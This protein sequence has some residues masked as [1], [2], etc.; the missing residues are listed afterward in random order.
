MRPTWDSKVVLVERYATLGGVCP[1][2]RLHSVQGAAVAAVMDEVSHMAD[3]GSSLAALWSTST[4]LRSHKGK[5]HW[6]AHRRP[7]G[8]V[9]CAKVTVVRGYGAFVGAHHVEV[10]ETTGT[11]QD[12]TGGRR[13]SPSRTPS[14]QRAAGPC[15]CRSCPTT[16]RG[17]FHRRPGAQ[18]IP[19]RMLILGGGIIGL[20]MGTVYSTWA[21]AWMWSK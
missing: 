5:G 15:A 18:E 9:R 12:K 6:Q 2:R 8:H 10:E 17:R 13:S 4:K 20:E 21:R 11:A 3:L 14:S 16:P 7:G 1:E 19:K